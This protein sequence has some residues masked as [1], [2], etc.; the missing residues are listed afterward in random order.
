MYLCTM[1]VQL[2]NY[3]ISACVCICVCVYLCVCVSVC[4]CIPQ[5]VG[6]CLGGVHHWIEARRKLVVVSQSALSWVHRRCPQLSQSALYIVEPSTDTPIRNP[7]TLRCMLTTSGPNKQTATRKLLIREYDVFR[8]YLFQ[9][10]DNS[11]PVQ[12]SAYGQHH[13]AY[14]IRDSTGCAVAVLDLYMPPTQELKPSQTKEV[15]KVLKLL[16]LA[17]YELS[18]I[19][20]RPT[21]TAESSGKHLLHVNCSL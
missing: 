9:C 4:V 17:Y 21:T 13:L 18:R 15:T 7:Y 19:P 3:Y 12:G 20:E 5:G 6:V 11:E 16:T 2:H 14:P 10:V 1:Y 8:D